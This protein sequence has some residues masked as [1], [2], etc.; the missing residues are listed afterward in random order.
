MKIILEDLRKYDEFL[1]PIVKTFSYI[2]IKIKILIYILRRNSYCLSKKKLNFEHKLFLLPHLSAYILRL[3]LRLI[4][5]YSR[6]IMRN[7]Y[8]ISYIHHL[9]CTFNAPLDSPH[10]CSRAAIFN[11]LCK[12][13][14][15][16]SINFAVL[17]P[18]PFNKALL[19][20]GCQLYS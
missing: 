9:H 17:Q 4:I 14:F 7:I 11:Q 8:F 16:I 2:L 18:P 13:N 10:S 6:E 3:S 20:I 5:Y 19:Y 12:Q 15:H 1:L